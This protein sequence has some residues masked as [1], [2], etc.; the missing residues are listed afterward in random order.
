MTRRTKVNAT[1]HYM[2]NSSKIIINIFFQTFFSHFF[3]ILNK[4]FFS[5]VMTVWVRLINEI[6]ILSASLIYESLTYLSLYSL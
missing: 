6:I 2:S 3:L 5:T 4:L 1:L